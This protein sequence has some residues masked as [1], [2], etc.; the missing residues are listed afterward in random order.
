MSNLNTLRSLPTVT[1]R[2]LLSTF[3]CTAL[4]LSLS[5]A[6]HEG[7]DG[8]HALSERVTLTGNV[9]EGRVVVPG[10]VR[11][12][13]P[14]LLRVERWPEVFSDA[15]A[16]A[17]GADGRWSL[18]FVRFQ[19]PHEFYVERDARRVVLVLADQSHG[20]ARF[21]Y[22]LEPLD[23]ERS[24]FRVRFTM[25]TPAGMTREQATTLLQGKAEADL[26]DF[27]RVATSLSVDRGRP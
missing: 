4:L 6:A 26:A 5:V 7:D 18:D 8:P 20:E 9:M 3:V 27:S 14:R 23:A 2:A 19:H 12:L 22:R 1:A 10:T 11:A 15:R 21:E 24:I 16:I 25:A 17:Q 13:Q